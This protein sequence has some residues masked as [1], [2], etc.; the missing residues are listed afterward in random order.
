MAGEAVELQLLVSAR[1]PGPGPLMRLDLTRTDGGE[2]PPW[3]PGSHLGVEVSGVGWRYYSLCGPLGDRKRYHIA[4]Q[5]EPTGRGG[6]AAVHRWTAGALLRATAP[7][8]HFH[9]QLQA[10]RHVLVAGGIGLTPMVP[11]VEWCESR[12]LPW[13]LHYGVRSEER[14]YFPEVL[15]RHYRHGRVYVRMDSRGERIDCAAL[16][17]AAMPGT[18]VYCCGPRG[19][20]DSMRSLGTAHPAV[21]IHFEAFEAKPAQDAAANA[22]FDVVCFESGLRLTVL[23]DQ[24]ML[25]ALEGAGI[26]WPYSCREGICGTCELEVIAGEPD[27][28]DAVL[29]AGERASSRKLMPCVSRARSHEI[30]VRC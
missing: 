2:L 5:H 4:V 3:T 6:S 25:D 9:L 30:V 13:E 10:R 26:A 16:L 24:S 11:M 28:R 22:S 14:R 18:H 20:M 15:D 21:P 27:H 17:A 8:N 12:G 19:L 7:R 1:T 29:S 23:P